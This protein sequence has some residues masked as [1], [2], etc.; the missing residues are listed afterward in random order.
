MLD[1]ETW[2]PCIQTAA[3]FMIGDM[4]IVI[5]MYNFELGGDIAYFRIRCSIDIEDQ[6]Y[7]DYMSDMNNRFRYVILMNKTWGNM[8]SLYTCDTA[9]SFHTE[10][11]RRLDAGEQFHDIVEELC[12]RGA[13]S[14]VYQ[15]I[16]PEEASKLT[17]KI[18]TSTQSVKRAM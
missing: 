13:F 14:F 6:E 16:P 2:G 10:F 8:R 1:K 11:A 5:D 15:D 17:E 12:Q 9:G 18:F 4:K 7:I 3:E